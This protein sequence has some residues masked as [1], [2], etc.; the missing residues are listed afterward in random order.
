MPDWRLGRR[1]RPAETPS[2]RTNYEEDLRDQS[3]VLTHVLALHPAHLTTPE[4]VREVV[5]GSADFEPD[6]RHERAVDDLCGAGL[7]NPAAGL[8]LPTRVAL[9]FHRLDR[10]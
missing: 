6:D 1:T 4:L 3:V 8:V 5:G 7:L 9:H 10:D 2:D